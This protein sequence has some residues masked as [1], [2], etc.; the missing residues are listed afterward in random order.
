MP[1]FRW[2]GRNASGQSMQ[3]EVSAASHDAVVDQL[4]R[5]R[6]PV[7]E[8][9]ADGE[10]VPPSFGA[11]A[12]PA[13]PPSGEVPSETLVERLARERAVGGGPRPFRGAAIAAVLI[14]VAFAVG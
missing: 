13:P 12:R 8:I 1:T 9:T 14:V 4:R 3:G 6:I 10:P 7:T 11:S 2:K 5:M